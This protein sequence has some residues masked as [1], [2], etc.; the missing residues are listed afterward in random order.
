M[1]QCRKETSS[2]GNFTHQFHQMIRVHQEPSCIHR[3][4]SKVKRSFC[5]NKKDRV[6][7]RLVA[8]VLPFRPGWPV[9]RVP[10]TLGPCLLPTRTSLATRLTHSLP[11]CSQGLQLRDYQEECIQSV[12]RSL[13]TG[14]KRLGVS[15]ATG[16]GKTVRGVQTLN[17]CQTIR[18]VADT[19]KGH[20]HS[21]HRS[22]QSAIRDGNPDSDSRP[23]AGA[24]GASRTPLFPGLPR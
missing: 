10:S 17:P 22:G 14:S 21:A 13:E 23:Q 24:R 1:T 6:M 5:F 19:V 15:L 3:H 16:S 4:G 11:Q 8:R 18:Y 2:T 7:E 12:L 9:K 20:I